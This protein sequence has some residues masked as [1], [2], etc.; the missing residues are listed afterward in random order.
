MSGGRETM[1]VRRFCEPLLP[2]EA[3]KLCFATSLKNW[4]SAPK[5]LLVTVGAFDII[6]EKI[7]RHP[8]DGN[9]EWGFRCFP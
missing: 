5:N 7:M 2:G 1:Q 9:E 4:I 6:R 8:A 3:K